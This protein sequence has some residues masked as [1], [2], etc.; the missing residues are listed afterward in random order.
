ML[1]GLNIQLYSYTT[2]IH[3][4]TAI[5]TIREEFNKYKTV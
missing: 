3:A 4:D 2:A 1:L 5:H